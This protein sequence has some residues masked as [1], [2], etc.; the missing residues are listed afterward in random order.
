MSSP[1]W[2]AEMWNTLMADP[3]LRE[4]YQHWFYLYDSGKPVAQSFLHLRK[5]IE[6]FVKKR[7]PE[8]NDPSLRQMVVIGHSQGGLLTKATAVEMSSDTLVRAATGKTLAELKL[9]PEDEKLIRSYTQFTPLPEVK[10]VIFISTPHR[11]SFLASNFVRRMVN[12]LIYA[13][14]QPI[15]TTSELM[16]L[17]AQ[18]SQPVAAA[19]SLDSM[20]P[21]NPALL[22][23]A[24]TPVHPTIKAHSIIAIKGDDTPPEGDDGVVAYSSAHLAGVESE[25][26]VRSGHSCQSMPKAIEEVRRILREHLRSQRKQ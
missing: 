13:P 10:R 7:D 12:W 18:K 5:S 21:E 23:F 20:S 22:A 6:A 15:H 4:N 11:G 3:V 25:C 14:L 24:E 8:G 9:S 26:I 17:F 1:V 16:K 2:W 19:T